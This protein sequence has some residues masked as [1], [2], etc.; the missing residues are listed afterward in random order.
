MYLQMNKLHSEIKFL[1][2]SKNLVNFIDDRE[3]KEFIY[4]LTFENKKDLVELKNKLEKVEGINRI[5]S[6]LT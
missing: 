2:E 5:N 6:D 4:K 1:E 3:A